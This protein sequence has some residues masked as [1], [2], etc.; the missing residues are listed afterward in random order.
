MEIPLYI[1]KYLLGLS[2]I[3]VLFFSSSLYFKEGTNRLLK[4]ALGWFTVLMVAN[5][6]NMIVTLNHFEKNSNK[7]G[8]KGPKGRIGP[9]G[10]KG[11][12]DTCG[13]ICGAAGQD[14]CE[15]TERDE[16]GKCQILG[17]EINDNGEP[18]L[19]TRIRPGKCVFP[20][21]YKYQKRYLGDGCVKDAA[22]EL[23]PEMTDYMEN[24]WCATQLNPDKTPKKVAYCGESSKE[25]ARENYNRAQAQQHDEFVKNNTGITDIKLISGNRSNIECPSGFTK[26]DKD[27]NEGSGGAYVY[28]CRK[29]GLASKGIQSIRVAQGREQCE[30]LFSDPSKYTEIKKLKT[31]LN[32]DT[33]IDGVEP[34]RL[35]MCLGYTDSKFLTDI[36]VTNEL[37]GAGEGFDLI[38]VNLNEKTDG[39]DLYLYT[40]N[41]RMEVNPLKTAF[42]Y[43]RDKKLYFFG[44]PDGKYYYIYEPKNGKVTSAELITNKFGK[45]PDN[46][47]AAFVWNYDEKTYFFK[48]KY[49][50]RYNYKTSSIEDGYPKVISREFKGVPNNIDAVFSWDKDGNTYFFKD[51]FLFK[52]DTEKKRVANGFPRLINARFP[53]APSKVDAVYFNAND[54]ET[55]FIQANQ[56]FILDSSEK[57]KAGY[58]KK[59]NLKYPGLGLLPNVNTFFTA[60][61]KAGGEMYFFG[62]D[63]YFKYTASGL[64]D[65]IMMND[66]DNS[67]FQGIPPVFDCV[68]N[69]E[70]NNE[71]VF[72]KGVNAY[73]YN[74]SSKDMVSGYPKKIED[75]YPGV[76]NNLD[77]CG[78]FESR[79]YFFKSNRVWKMKEGNSDVE[80]GYPKNIQ[81]EFPKMPNNIDTFTKYLDKY[82]VIKGIQYY[83]VKQDKTIDIKSGSAEDAQNPNKY[84]QYLDSKFTNLNTAADRTNILNNVAASAAPAPPS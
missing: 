49:V 51:K 30:D 8:P 21:V 3:I 7:I 38:N 32:K 77:A 39:A 23:F 35:F 24:G 41:T 78:I 73:K 62:N 69:T 9:K 56:Y 4:I 13:S 31:D 84:P 11:K 63:K 18:I 61:G 80:E 16:N 75:E 43:Q 37:E 42:F 47:D 57:V 15:E 53:G 28:M 54:N 76:P 20:F 26:V 14:Q 82:Y 46:L 83:I 60:V 74:L 55:Y 64:Q 65:G 59:L 17:N 70:L 58:P 52:Y 2:I 10:F 34:E 79:I 48:G 12:S 29:D 45:L 27:L 40:S 1:Y 6:V 36:K 67:E 68:L 19:D 81:E 66:K 44:G 71:F 22:P 33:A 25:I 50:Y 72:F 5:L